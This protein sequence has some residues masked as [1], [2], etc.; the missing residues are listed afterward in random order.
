VRW[1]AIDDATARATIADAGLSV[2]MD[3]HFAPDGAITHVTAMRYR[4]VNGVGVLTPFV[5]WSSDYR[6]IAGM[7]V[8]R[9]TEATWETPDGPHT[10][11]RADLTG[12]HYDL[13]GEPRS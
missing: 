13:A 1:T 3:A 11:W 12:I 6:R 5:G 9:H 8:P 2:S 10:F 7:M 4:D